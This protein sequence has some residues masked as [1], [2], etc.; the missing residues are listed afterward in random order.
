M[1]AA[2]IFLRSD[3][4]KKD[5]ENL[6][7]WLSN[8]DVTYFLNEDHSVAGELQ[9]LVYEVPP[10]MYGC[11]FNRDGTFYMVCHEEHESIGF[12][13][14]KEHRSDLY[15]I[16]FAIGE[17]TLWGNGFGTAAV[18]K[19]INHAFFV[20]RVKKVIARIY[21]EN[22]RSVATVRGCGFKLEREGSRFDVYSITFEEYLDRMRCAS[23]RA[24]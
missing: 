22:K 20:D 5:A 2:S 12:V 24:V 15:E 6:S 18:S 14:F 21:K 1:R 4:N 23:Q 17:E 16:V 10:F 3:I 13:R 7:R 9:R 19:A 8:K 11:Y